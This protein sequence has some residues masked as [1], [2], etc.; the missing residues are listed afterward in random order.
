MSIAE[1]YEQ[2]EKYASNS[3]SKP[4]LFIQ[5]YTKINNNMRG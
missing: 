4:D 5:T 1:Q 3:N 2:E